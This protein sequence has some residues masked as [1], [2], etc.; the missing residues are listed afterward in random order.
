MKNILFLLTPFLF[1]GM[2]IAQPSS[3]KIDRYTIATDGPT[4]KILVLKMPYANYTVQSITGDT[5]AFYH[6]GEV[7]VDVICTDFPPEQSLVTLNANRLKAFFNTFPFIKRAQ[8]NRVNYYRQTGG[9]ERTKAEPMFH[10]VVVR[11]RLAQNAAKGGTELE[12]L[13]ALLVSPVK[14]VKKTSLREAAE[15][16]SLFQKTEKTI[17]LDATGKPFYYDP[18]MSLKG[19]RITYIVGDETSLRERFNIA[20]SLVIIDFKT[21]YKN[22]LIS[23]RVYQQFRDNQHSYITLYVPLPEEIPVDNSYATKDTLATVPPPLPDSTLVKVLGRNNWKNGAVIT[24]A[25]GS[26][27]PY[28]AQLLI[29]LQLYSLSSLSNQYVFFNDGDDKEDDKKIPG[30]TGGIYFN[31]CFHYEQV[32]HLLT[33]TMQK[34]AGG[35]FPENVAEALLLA[36]KQFPDAAF[37]ILVADNW[38]AIRDKELLGKLKKPVRVILCGVQNNDVNMDYLNLAF[39]TKGTLHL[40]EQDINALSTLKEGEVLAI[41]LKKYKCTGGELVEME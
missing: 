19:K 29:W 34:G 30:K 27:Y 2:A 11:Y 6:A 37:N 38:A 12:K 15:T 13:E 20:D 31:R 25:T 21:A 4:Q 23:K 26:M 16:A 14:S 1:A 5:S 9:S 8:V 22:K 35:D 33:T 7:V 18:S 28:T 40:V 10:G 41:G 39:K 17:P 36:E 32:K 24:D 3:I